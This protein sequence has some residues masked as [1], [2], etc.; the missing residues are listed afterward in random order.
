MVSKLGGRIQ[1]ILL[2][3]CHFEMG[4]AKRQFWQSVLWN[5]R[6]ESE[7]V[8][9]GRHN[10]IDRYAR[11]RAQRAVGRHKVFLFRRNID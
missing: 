9:I 11:G 4:N 1:Q 7:L 6:G 8:R 3:E 2:I 5:E 10:D